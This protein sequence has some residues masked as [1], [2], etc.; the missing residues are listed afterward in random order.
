MRTHLF[1]RVTRFFSLKFSVNILI[2]G[3]ICFILNDFLQL[4]KINY[5]ILRSNTYL[6]YSSRLFS[7]PLFTLTIIWV[8]TFYFHFVKLL[9][10]GINGSKILECLLKWIQISFCSNFAVISNFPGTTWT[11]LWP[12]SS[13]KI[14]KSVKN[15][16]QSSHQKNLRRL[17]T[18]ENWCLK[19]AL[20]DSCT[21]YRLILKYLHEPLGAGKIQN[22]KV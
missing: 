5:Q 19:L 18:S 10:Y 13:D 22:K 8:T 4:N 7:K 12:T 15:H 3:N 6:K 1:L 9:L 21:K 16:L 14:K 17:C 11:Q 2:S 20:V